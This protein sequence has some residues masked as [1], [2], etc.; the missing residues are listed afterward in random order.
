M[1]AFCGSCWALWSITLPLT[2]M[3]PPKVSIDSSQPGA[4]CS[5]TCCLE[6]TSKLLFLRFDSDLKSR[7]LSTH[8][9]KFLSQYWHC[10]PCKCLLLMIKI[11]FI[12]FFKDCWRAVSECGPIS[13]TLVLRIY[14]LRLWIRHKGIQFLK[15]AW[16]ILNCLVHR[17][18]C[19]IIAKGDVNSVN[20]AQGS[21]WK[22][23]RHLLSPLK[24][25]A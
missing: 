24:K 20:K 16:M 10:I 8:G 7:A 23:V 6:A 11:M 14:F 22:S 4:L 15:L 21:Q 2:P 1:H 19:K 3:L 9:Y 12:G 18:Y 13:Q 25:I 5:M 17:L